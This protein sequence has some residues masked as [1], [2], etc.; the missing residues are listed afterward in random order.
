MPAQSLTDQTTGHE[1]VEGEVGTPEEGKVIAAHHDTIIT[2]PE[3]ELAVQIPEGSNDGRALNPLGVH[4]EQTP[5][6]IIHGETVEEGTD[7]TVPEDP[8]P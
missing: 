8:A 4:A 3:D 1:I 5:A 6:E 7:D 2:D